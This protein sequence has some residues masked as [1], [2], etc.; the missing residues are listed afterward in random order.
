MTC[1][2]LR[3]DP[4]FPGDGPAWNLVPPGQ[5]LGQEAICAH[6][7]PVGWSLLASGGGL[8]GGRGRLA[9]AGH[10]SC[11]W[12]PP[13]PAAPSEVIS[14]APAFWAGLAPTVSPQMPQVGPLGTGMGFL[15]DAG[16]AGSAEGLQGREGWKVGWKEATEN[17]D[18][19]GQRVLVAADK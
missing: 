1:P 5:E 9:N 4:P 10:L 19:R 15:Q 14:P 17:Q 3:R 11:E 18:R 7:C 12:P 13:P 2:G 16:R 8:A 6:P